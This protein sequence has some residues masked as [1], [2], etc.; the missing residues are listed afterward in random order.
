MSL[1]WLIGP[2]IALMFVSHS[3]T[4]TLS[5]VVAFVLLVAVPL[6]FVC[7]PRT[8]SEAFLAATTVLVVFVAN[9]LRRNLGLVERPELDGSKVDMI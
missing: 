5:L 2:M 3:R 4:L 6:P 9:T 7:K 8:P 1:R